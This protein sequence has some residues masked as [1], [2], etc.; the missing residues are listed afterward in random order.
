[1]KQKTDR[2]RHE[3]RFW[4]FAMLVVNWLVFAM[5]VV[6]LCLALTQLGCAFHASGALGEA[7]VREQVCE[8][9]DVRGA[10]MSPTLGGILSRAVDAA[11][12]FF[13]AGD[14]PLEVA[15]PVVD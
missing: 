1:V 11:A 7:A 6:I 2:E 15:P 5:L 10:A 4:V 9:V 8:D 13:G 14:P 12:R 3:R